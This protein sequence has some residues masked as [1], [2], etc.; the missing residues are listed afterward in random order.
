VQS[1]RARE[2]FVCLRDLACLED[3]VD[4]VV[5][6]AVRLVHRRLPR[7]QKTPVGAEQM[8]KAPKGAQILRRR[9]VVVVMALVAR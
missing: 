7:A 2:C 8:I 1:E 6:S 9:A 3:L 5:W 4:G